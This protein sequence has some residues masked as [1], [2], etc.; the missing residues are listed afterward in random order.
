M[1]TRAGQIGRGGMRRH[2][3]LA[4]PRLVR[5]FDDVTLDEGDLRRIVAL[6]VLPLPAPQT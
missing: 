3:P 2:P 4:N 1:R 5:R 6:Q